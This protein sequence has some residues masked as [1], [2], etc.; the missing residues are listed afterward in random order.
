MVSLRPIPILTIGLLFTLALVAT[1]AATRPASAQLAI[2]ARPMSGASAV[3]PNLS[4]ASGLAVVTIDPDRLTM[5][6]EVW[7]AGLTSNATSAHLHCCS[8][9]GVSAIVA[10][11]SPWFLDFPLGVPSGSYD[12]TFD[13]T[14][15]SI[16]NPAFLTARGGS[17]AIAIGSLIA[18]LDA[19]QA[20]VD[21]HDVIFPGG[22]IRALLI[23]VPEPRME[24]A[25]VVG[26]FA[27]A[28]RRRRR[29]I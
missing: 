20:Y 13:L 18:G 3:P 10:I 19:G 27:A 2:W 14:A 1:S 11:Q 23:P 8:V 7:Y 4:P 22:E 24:G 29:S 15:P 12:R 21:V 6:V 16:W 28:A 17:I 26:L 9:P 25:L 5:R